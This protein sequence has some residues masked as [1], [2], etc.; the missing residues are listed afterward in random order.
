MSAWGL[1]QLHAGLGF[2]ALGSLNP[3]GCPAATKI[4]RTQVWMDTM[5]DWSWPG[6]GGAAAEVLPPPW[7][8]AFPPRREPVAAPPAPA[9]GTYALA[10]HRR[11]AQ[12]ARRRLRRARRAGS[13]E[14]RA[15][16]RHRQAA[17]RSHSPPSARARPR[18]RRCPRSCPTPYSA[19]ASGSAIDTASYH[20][21]ALRRSGSFFVYLPPGYASTTRH[22]PV[23]YLLH[24]NSQPATAFLQIGLQEEL[25]QLI[26]AT[27][28]R[29]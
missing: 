16:A 29:R 21:A 26:A 20:S 11:A 3:L 5:G 13:A 17:A 22:Y 19:D 4:S 23:L 8:P 9:A 10:D 6:Q 12:R 25:D 14:H 28:S 1:G 27:P 7:V 15:T 24:G 18:P 2:L